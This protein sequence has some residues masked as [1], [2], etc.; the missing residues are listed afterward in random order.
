LQRRYQRTAEEGIKRLLKKELSNLDDE[1][2][3]AVETWTQVLA[4]RFAHIPCLGLRGLMNTGPDGSIDAFLDGLEPE[5]ADE[6]RQALAMGQV[7]RHEA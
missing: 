3:K 1:Q 6:L 5:F 7:T 4:R 2:R